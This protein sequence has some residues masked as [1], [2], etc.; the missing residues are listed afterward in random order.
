M[1]F[2]KKRL[3]EIETVFRFTFT[4]ILIRDIVRGKIY[5]DF[6][7]NLVEICIQNCTKRIYIKPNRK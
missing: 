3:T 1:Y 6:V 2:H 5:L 7:N 4:I